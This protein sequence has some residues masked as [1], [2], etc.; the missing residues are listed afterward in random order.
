[1]VSTS[2]KYYRLIIHNARFKNAYCGLIFDTPETALYCLQRYVN[3]Y[4]LGVVEYEIIPLKLCEMLENKDC[5][6]TRLG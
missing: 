4:R 2:K 3:I 6:V 1:M 5:S